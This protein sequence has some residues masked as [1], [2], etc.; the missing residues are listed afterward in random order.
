MKGK[1]QNWKTAQRWA[2]RTGTAQTALAVMLSLYRHMLV[3]ST[4]TAA[5]KAASI[6]PAH[7]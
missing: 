2:S 1:K 4:T 6:P 3:I 5:D 7:F